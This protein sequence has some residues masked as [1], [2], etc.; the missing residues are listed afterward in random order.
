MKNHV[1]IITRLSSG[2]LVQFWCSYCTVPLNIIITQMR[3]R[4]KKA[5][6]AESVR[7]SLHSWCKRGKKRSRRDSMNSTELHGQSAQLEST[8]GERHE[9]ITVGSNTLGPD[10]LSRCSPLGSPNEEIIV[11]T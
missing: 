4:C 3:S 10:S 1:T 11:P 8:I 9:I 2:V 6:V 5:L 7:E